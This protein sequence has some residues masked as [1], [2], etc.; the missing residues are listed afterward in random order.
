MIV[1]WHTQTREWIRESLA[2]ALL[3]AVILEPWHK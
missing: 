3:S 2:T 1:K